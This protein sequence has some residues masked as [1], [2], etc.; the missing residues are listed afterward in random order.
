MDTELESLRLKLEAIQSSEVY[1]GYVAFAF[2]A[3][4]AGGSKKHL[5]KTD[6]EDF[7]PPMPEEWINVSK[8]LNSPI[9]LDDIL[10]KI[11]TE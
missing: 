5:A 4:I 6:K 1:G 3:K 7:Q 2:S 10:K 9:M 8:P 11:W